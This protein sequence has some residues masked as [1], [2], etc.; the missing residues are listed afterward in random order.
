MSKIYAKAS[1]AG[2]GESKADSQGITAAKAG[3]NDPDL[4]FRQKVPPHH[5]ANILDHMFR[6][7]L[8]ASRLPIHIRYFVFDETEPSVNH[9]LRLEP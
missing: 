4:V 1:C 2:T 3:Q 5:R 9:T 7:T 6:G 8:A